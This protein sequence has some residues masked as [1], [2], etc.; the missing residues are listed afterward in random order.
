MLFAVLFYEGYQ[1]SF[2]ALSPVRRRCE[3]KGD[4]ESLNRVLTIILLFFLIALP[5]CLAVYAARHGNMTYVELF[6]AI[7][8][9]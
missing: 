9:C 8:I 7:E 2:Q 3:E 4:S 6:F 1:K 5:L